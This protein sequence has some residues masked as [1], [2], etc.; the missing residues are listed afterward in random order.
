MNKNQAYR[1]GFSARPPR[2]RSS[3][4]NK[5][6]EN[7]ISP[8][9]SASI[10][11]RATVTSTHRQRMHARPYIL[12]KLVP[13][14]LHQRIRHPALPIRRF[15]AWC[16]NWDGVIGPWSLRV[17]LGGDG[18]RAVIPVGVERGREVE[19]DGDVAG[20]VDGVEGVKR[21]FPV[22]RY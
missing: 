18:E 15:T 10:S 12:P 22:H 8:H 13:S 21:V 16:C 6:R 2:A 11:P 5:E 3:T 1:S 4:P 20:L 17:D 7:T 14:H 19:H 9:Q